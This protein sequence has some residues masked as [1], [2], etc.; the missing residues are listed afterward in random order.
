MGHVKSNSMPA[1]RHIFRFEQRPKL[2]EQDEDTYI[3]TMEAVHFASKSQ[4]VET[5]SPR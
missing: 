1:Y 4:E 2:S 3:E 5:V